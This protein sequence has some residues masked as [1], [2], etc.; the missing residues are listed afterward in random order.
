M[1]ALDKNSF[2]V[3][4]NDTGTGYFKDQTTQAR[5]PSQDR[6]LV[7][8][9]KDS[10]VNK[11]DIDVYVSNIVSTSGTDTYTATLVPAISAYVTHHYYL[12]KFV[13]ANTGAATLNL[14]GLGAKSIVKSGS[15]PL[16][17][18][19]IAA[20]QILELAYDGTNLQIV[21]GSGSSSG[22][23]DGGSF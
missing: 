20:G 13:N 3:K 23:I 5:V 21:G 6:A 15:N 8:D 10:F 19:D 17:L 18:G 1:A 9:I 22:S 4:Y 11:N 2:E 12:I 7:T 16:I 14:N